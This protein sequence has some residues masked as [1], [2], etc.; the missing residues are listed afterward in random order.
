MAISRKITDRQDLAD[1]HQRG[2]GFVLY[3][4]GRKLHA[5]S[6][7]TIPGMALNPEEPRWFAPDAVA[8]RKYQ[9]DRLGRYPNSQPFERVRCCASLVPD[10]AVIDATR[11]ERPSV[12]PRKTTESLQNG[13]GHGRLWTSRMRSRSV[14]LWTTRR[15]PFETDQSAQQKAMVRELAPNVASLRCDRSERLHGVFIS[16]ETSSKQPDAENIVF[17]NFGSA[18]FTAGGSVLAFE[19]SYS[20]APPPPRPLKTSAP[21]YHIWS[22]VPENAPFEHWIERDIVATWND[23]PFELTGDLGLAAWRSLREHPERVTVVSRL[24]MSDRY[25]IDVTLTA[26]HGKEPSIVKAVK[27]LVD[28]PL[29]GL[30]R[31]DHLAPDVVSRLL[32]RHWGRPIDEPTLLNLVSAAAPPQ[33]L[34]R[35]PFNKNGLDPCDEFCVAGIGR[36]VAT[37]GPALMTGKVFRVVPR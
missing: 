9:A 7:P 8:A 20:Q 11:T 22:V 19:R 1:I 29:A 17:Y 34:P 21:Y 5:A 26:P 33:L 37:S 28:G 15:T 3:P 36:V 24:G 12:P 16:D 6:C 2:V 30:Q 25:G 32:R 27:G 10:D 4:F 13:S 31:A 14:E 35:A 23:V 18:P